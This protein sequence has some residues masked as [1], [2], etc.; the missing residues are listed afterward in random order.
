MSV[1][2]RRPVDA[3][4]GRAGCASAAGNGGAWRLSGLL[5]EKWYIMIFTFIIFLNLLAN[6]DADATIIRIPVSLLFRAVDLF[7][8]LSALSPVLYLS[9]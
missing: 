7:L 3:R 2:R 6:D 8:N 4:L 5:T 9:F 1:I